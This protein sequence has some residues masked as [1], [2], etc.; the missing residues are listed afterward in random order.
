[1]A[2]HNVT[3]SPILSCLWASRLH[4]VPIAF[5][6]AMG[7]LHSLLSF[8]LGKWSNPTMGL[9]I[10]AP[11]IELV[12]NKSLWVFAK[13]PSWRLWVWWSQAPLVPHSFLGMSLVCP[14]STSPTTKNL[15]PAYPPFLY[16]LVVLCMFTALSSLCTP[17]LSPQ[18]WVFGVIVT[19]DFVS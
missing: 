7:A 11:A 8:P 9:F 4:V 16:H 15:L 12:E 17:T 5:L 3:Y 2:E 14:L 13:S 6:G 1:M 10:S 19:A 18:D